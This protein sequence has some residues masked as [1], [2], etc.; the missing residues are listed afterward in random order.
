M[1]ERV[2]LATIKYQVI[3]KELR[4]IEVRPTF[5]EQNPSAVTEDWKKPERYVTEEWMETESIT[6]SSPAVISGFLASK[7]Q[8]LLPEAT[9]SIY[10]DR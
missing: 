7:A 3:V 2:V 6:G 4:K 8:E 1:P 10:K 9:V 5:E